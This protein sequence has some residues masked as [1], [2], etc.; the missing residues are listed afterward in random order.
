V[1]VIQLCGDLDGRVI[2]FQSVETRDSNGVT[3][4]LPAYTRMNANTPHADNGGADDIELGPFS[5]ADGDIFTAVLRVPGGNP[6][7]VI[8]LAFS[9]TGTISSHTPPEPEEEEWCWWED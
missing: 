8:Q 6:E 2:H 3:R 7:R 9:F 5:P 4:S 1:L